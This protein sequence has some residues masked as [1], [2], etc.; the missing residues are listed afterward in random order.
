MEIG[1][2]PGDLKSKELLARLARRYPAPRYAL[3]PQVRSNTGLEPGYRMAD[4][5]AMSLWP[6]RGLTIEGFEIKTSRRDWTRELEDPGKADVI[7][8]LCDRW[9][10]VAGQAEIVAPGELPDAWGL[11]VPDDKGSLA[12]LAPAV[13][14]PNPDPPSRDF[15]AAVL[16]RAWEAQPSTAAL[17]AARSAGMRD[18]WRALAERVEAFEQASGVQIGTGDPWKAGRIGKAVQ[19]VL[20]GGTEAQVARLERLAQNLERV[21]QQVKEETANLKAAEGATGAT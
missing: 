5:V 17:E 10:V 12:I 7:G 14:N 9:W 21:L 2:R 18:E 3:L 20:T 16:Q 1:M 8:R 19:A 15:I 13:D 11:L 6:S 4:A